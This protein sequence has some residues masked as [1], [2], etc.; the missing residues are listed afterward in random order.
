MESPENSR[1][2]SYLEDISKLCREIDFEDLN[3][4]STLENDDAREYVRGLR[5]SKPEALLSDK[6]FKPII[7]YTELTNFPEGRMGEGWVDFVLESS[8]NMGFPVAVELKALHNRFGQMISLQSIFAAMKGEFEKQKSNQIVK[9]IVG[10][11]GVEYVILTNLCDVFIFDKSCVINFEPVVQESFAKLIEGIFETRNISEYLKRRTRDIAKHGL[12]K[13][14]IRDLKK[15]YGY[16]QELRWLE[17]PK[18][19]S[20]LLLNKLIFALTLED[21]III[22]YRYTWDTFVSAYNKWITKGPKKVLEVFFAEM[23]GF[24]Y[25]YYDTELFIPSNSILSK[26]EQSRENYLKALD[27][28]KRVA[29][30]DDRVAVFSEGL[31]SYSFRLID[32][33]VFGKSYETFLAENRR[34][35]GIYYTPKEITG[36]MSHKLVNELFY[37]LAEQILSRIN[38]ND[39]DGAM[40]VADRFISLG[41]IDPAC[42][43]GPFL[44]GVLREIYHIY[45]HLAK[46]T[47]WV[48]NQFRNNSLFLPRDIE[49]KI[50]RTK[51]L[52]EKLGVN[53][54]K[55]PRALFSKIILR[56]IFGADID[57]TALSVAKVNLWK[58]TIKLNPKSFYFQDLPEDDNHIL[59]DLELN[60]IN[61]NS[62]VSLPDDDIINLM[63]SEFREKI[64]EMVK[65][66]EEYVENPTRSEIPGNIQLIKERIRQRLME[67]F[68]KN[69]KS[70]SNPLF[71]PLEYFFFYFDKN[72]I[73]RESKDRGFAGAI[74]NPPWNNLKSNKKEFAAK[75]P[76][77]FGEGVSKYSM[78]GKEFEKVF[79]EKL[80]SPEVKGTWDSYVQYFKALSKYISAN[81]RLQYSGD[82][83]L[84]KVFAEKFLELS[85][86]AF[87]ILIPSNF[88]TDEG[89]FLLRKE[90]VEKWEIREL[91]SFENRSKAWFPDIHAQFKFDMLMVSRN[92]SGKPFKAR[93]YV[94][95]WQQIE[96]AFDYPAQLVKKLSPIVMGITEFRSSADISIVSKIRGNYRLLENTGL[97]L[98]T[99][100]HETNDKDI[101]SESQDGLILYEGKMMH[102][103]NSHFSGNKYRVDEELGRERLLGRTINRIQERIRDKGYKI[104]KKVIEEGI[105][106]RT[107]KM[108]YENERLVFRDVARATDERTLISCVLPTGA[109]LAN[110]LPYVE[111]F[112][113]EVGREYNIE[114][115]SIGDYIYY[116][117][118]LFNS[119]ILDYY[120]RQRVTSHLNFFFVYELPIPDVYDGLEREII[121]KSRQL[122][123]NDDLILRAELEAMIAEKVFHLNSD[124][125]K[126]VLDSFVYGNVSEL[127]KSEILKRVVS[128]P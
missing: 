47:N 84:Q 97:V 94:T 76:E 44:I 61:G 11:K 112:N 83:S 67:E 60:F 66:H 110:T 126:I 93:F 4:S 96:E 27:I 87:C 53:G 102:Q 73:Q 57:P 105:K 56:H 117:Q 51:Q 128:K 79:S 81:Y 38:D 99:E 10:Q 34:D 33:D 20:V 125:T 43:S 26:L 63:Q 45:E 36:H 12:D 111:P 42:G 5:V 52:R 22:D 86:G 78:T 115:K 69:N 85:K 23:D 15:W 16:L 48:E 107:I 127:L 106:K 75:H 1:I 50:S 89:T 13:L 35:S 109:F 104:D 80:S 55:I 101:F 77:I 9:Y 14:F 114:Q 116:I 113:M 28:L 54:D 19:S 40:E 92:I 8:K 59:P 41:I 39:F 122:V 18:T 123:N 72:G 91:I 29:G 7:K 30:F 74:G 32:E 95:E 71:F 62:V 88:H 17:D 2:R 21:F 25:E 121:N 108:D 103:Y 46:K 98:R 100:L 24:L 124:E 31:Y 118:A 64:V 119:F 65:L 68:N 90:I 120:V 3:F 82:F 49:D 70:F 6:L 58:E 37:Q